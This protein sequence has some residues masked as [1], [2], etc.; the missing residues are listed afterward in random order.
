MVTRRSAPSQP[1]IPAG[2]ACGRRPHALS[3]TLPRPAPVSGPAS[4]PAPSDFSLAQFAPL[5]PLIP[6][7]SAHDGLSPLLRR[8]LPPLEEAGTGVRGDTPGDHRRDARCR[9]A[10]DCHGRNGRLPR[11][12]PREGLGRKRPRL[13]AR[14]RPISAKTARH[15]AEGRRREGCDWRRP[16]LDQSDDG[17]ARRSHG[18]GRT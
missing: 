16:V 17:H 1:E 14:I 12:A 3:E 10:L 7:E 13:G 4:L 5:S 8:S 11:A 9:G 18:H 15:H 6:R 2:A